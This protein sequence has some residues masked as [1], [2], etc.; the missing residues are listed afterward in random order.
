[1]RN[2][3]RYTGLQGHQIS[4]S[5]EKE[6]GDESTPQEMKQQELNRAIMPLRPS[7]NLDQSVHSDEEIEER[8][9]KNYYRVRDEQDKT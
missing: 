7:D 2:R 8:A 3:G 9:N 6:I 1:M 5:L 4:H